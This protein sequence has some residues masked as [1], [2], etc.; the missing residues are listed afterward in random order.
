MGGNPENLLALS[1]EIPGIGESEYTQ[2]L[3]MKQRQWVDL[4][5]VVATLAVGQASV[6][7]FYS[8]H[9]S[10]ANKSNEDRIGLAIRL[11]KCDLSRPNQGRGYRS[12]LLCGDPAVAQA[13]GFDL[14]ELAPQVEFGESKC[15]VNS[16]RCEYSQN[17]G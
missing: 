13:C 2:E 12:T 1:Q 10:K 4:K 14:E 9:A 16:Q 17:M 11:V 7:S 3:S 6:H 15:F 5:S 8:I